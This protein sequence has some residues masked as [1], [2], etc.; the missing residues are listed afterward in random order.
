MTRRDAVATER[1]AAA[2]RGRPAVAGGRPLARPWAGPLGLY[3]P[4]ST[5]LH[6]APVAARLAAL[7]ALSVL[8]VATR[9]PWAALAGA[10]FVGLL[11]A[12]ARVPWR[13]V[14]AALAVA[15]L[16]GGYRAWAGAPAQGLAAGLD[17]LALVL[18]GA[19]LVAVTP[20]DELLAAV[21]AAARPFRRVGARPERVALAAVLMLRAV[22]ALVGA[23]S[24]SR[25]A[26]RARGAER[27][28]RTW[29]TPAAVRAVARAHATGEALAARG[30]GA[31]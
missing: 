7:A 4:G 28:P 10:G 15:A 26:A 27:D 11:A 30:L 8:V 12:W 25:D 13:A 2:S 22:P 3:R 20:A 18:A 9:G 5:Q 29:L 6:R 16:V 31:D 14:R 21:A 23:L 24:Q 19:V 1:A 17:L